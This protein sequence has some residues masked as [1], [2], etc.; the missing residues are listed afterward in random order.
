MR[1]KIDHI[2][3]RGS[4]AAAAD[5]QASM[6]VYAADTTNP[7]SVG[8][9]QTVWNAGT[10]GSSQATGTTPITPRTD[11][12]GGY[13][14]WVAQPG[15]YY[16]VETID[17]ITMPAVTWY[18]IQGRQ[19]TWVTATLLNSWA[20]GLAAVQYTI[21]SRGLVKLRGNATRG[22]SGVN[23][24]IFQLPAG[25][26]PGATVTNG[27]CWGAN[28]VDITTAGNVTVTT[29]TPTNVWLDPLCCLAEA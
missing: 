27:G 26:R 29:G 4:G 14:W 16:L 18:A 1:V 9:A 3:R 19:D 6:V 23:L 21:D 15:V 8:A 25:F 5:T 7:G 10:G 28:T 12:S 13:D 24:P 2:S 20:T 17:G 22:S 11:G